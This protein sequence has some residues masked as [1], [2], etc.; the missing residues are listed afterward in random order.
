MTETIRALREIADRFDHVL[1]DQW[2]ALHEGKA[3]FPEA[4]DCVLALHSAGK[5]ILVLSNSGKRAEDN[6]QRLVKMGLPAE[7][8]DG[9]LSSGEVAWKSLRDRAVPPFST[10]GRKC[11]LIA[12]GWGGSVIDGLDLTQV[13]DMAQADFILL[14][15]LD[16]ADADLGRWRAALTQAAARKTPMLCANPDLTMFGPDGGLLPAPGAVA[17][18]YE[19]LGGSVDYLGKPH[20]PIFTVALETLG[21]PDPQRVLMIGDSLD[22]DILGGREAG[23]LTLLITSG[24]HREALSGG[25]ELADLAGSEARMPHWVIDR[26]VW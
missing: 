11:F 17:R 12:R 9:V 23:V 4:K 26:L 19:E 22:H 6:L 7:S 5:R 24:V 1:L 13:T 18:L 14:A 15:G 8:Y 10:L 25:A 3:L 20:R 2:G 16:D 21:N